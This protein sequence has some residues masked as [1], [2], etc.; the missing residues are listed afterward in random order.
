MTRRSQYQCGIDRNDSRCAVFRR[1][2]VRSQT[3]T[4]TR[5]RRG[6]FAAMATDPISRRAVQAGSGRRCANRQSPGTRRHPRPAPTT[7]DAELPQ[8]WRCWSDDLLDHSMPGR[9][10]ILSYARLPRPVRR[11]IRHLCQ[12]DPRP[13]PWRAIDLPF[14][15]TRAGC[16][17][18]APRVC[19]ERSAGSS[20]GG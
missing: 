13:F 20:R 18:S 19:W 7:P 17:C 15:A 11:A 5:V 2:R 12:T 4:G 6:H 14:S 16:S 9:R 10:G 8:A 1:S 3:R